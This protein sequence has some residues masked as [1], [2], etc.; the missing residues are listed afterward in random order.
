MATNPEGVDVH[1]TPMGET[2]PEHADEGGSAYE[3]IGGGATVRL[4]VDEL[5]KLILADP[6]LK[7]YFEGVEMPKLKVHMVD[8]LTTVL[9]GP[10]QY[11]GRE[12]ADAHRGLEI[13]EEHYRKVGEY[14]IGLLQSIGAPDDVVTSVGA[15]LSAVS[16]Q[17][18]EEPNTES[19]PGGPGHDE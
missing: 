2:E 14:L 11:T 3:R 1:Q 18:I 6:E 5:Y 9:G 7:D 4:A 19:T 12:L 16:D 8:L 15:T 17:V 10:N 13:T